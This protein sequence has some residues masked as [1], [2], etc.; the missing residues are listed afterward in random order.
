MVVCFASKAQMNKCIKF[1][2]EHKM[3]LLTQLENIKNL[4]YEVNKFHFLSKIILLARGC[5]RSRGN[6]GELY[7]RCQNKRSNIILLL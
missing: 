7:K 5:K 1:W 3:Q 2:K 6:N 4:Y